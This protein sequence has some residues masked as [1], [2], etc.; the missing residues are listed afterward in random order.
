MK[1]TWSKL[2]AGIPS[3]NLLPFQITTRSIDLS[4]CCGNFFPFEPHL[5]PKWSDR[6]KK[7]LSALDKTWVVAV[8]MEFR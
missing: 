8:K 4:M 6:R 1:K 7:I 3:R 5:N 2:N